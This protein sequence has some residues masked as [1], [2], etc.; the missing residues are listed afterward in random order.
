[1]SLEK[2]V[3]MNTFFLRLR[4]YPLWAPLGPGPKWAKG[5]NGPGPK[6]ARAQVGQGPSGPGAQV[7]QGLLLSQNC[8]CQFT[9]GSNN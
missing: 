8:Y 5:P 1:M 9:G 6:W 4:K 2:K 3:V 7:G